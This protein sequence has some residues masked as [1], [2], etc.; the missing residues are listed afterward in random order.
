MLWRRDALGHPS[1][2]D[3]LVLPSTGVRL[4]YNSTE[5]FPNA[6]NCT[7]RHASRVD[8]RARRFYLRRLRDQALKGYGSIGSS[9][10]RCLI[11][12]SFW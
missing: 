7:H 6:P 9:T 4:P 2:L 12:H 11:I 5:M 3:A 8:D 10:K 1:I